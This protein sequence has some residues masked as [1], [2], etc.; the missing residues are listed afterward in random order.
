MSAG[1]QKVQPEL[2]RWCLEDLGVDMVNHFGM[3]EGITIGNRWDS[4]KEP[5]MYT[6]GFPHIIAPELQVKIVDEN[7]QPVKPGEIGEMVVKG[8]SHFKGYFRNPEQNKLSFDEHGFF[9]SGDLMSQRE[10]GRFV[11]E[12]R[13]GDVIKRAGEN[14]YPEPVEALLLHHPKVVNTAVIGVPDARL[15]EKLCCFIQPKEGKTITFEEIQVYLKEKGM[16]VFQWPE[17]LEIITAWPLTAV[18]KI[19]KRSLRAHIATKLFNEGAI[20]KS[21]GDEYL[22]RDKVTID[23]VISCRMKIEFTGTPQ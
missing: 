17:R 13:K 15:G 10:D 21:L 4:P 5:Q 18:N 3:S 2:V 12:G 1:G 11:V 19:D 6:I 22:R 20:E 8:P 9:H 14:V 7:N 23:D 16:A